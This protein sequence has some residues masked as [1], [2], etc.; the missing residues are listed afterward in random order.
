MRE[1]SFAI[2]ELKFN[3]PHN[4][5]LFFLRICKNFRNFAAQN[6]LRENGANTRLS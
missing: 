4:F 6:K 5:S 3:I 1:K 2:F